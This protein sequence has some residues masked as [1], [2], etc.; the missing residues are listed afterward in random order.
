MNAETARQRLLAQHEQI[1]GCLAECSAL[2]HRL[3]DGEPT[4]IQFDVALS[5]LRSLFD[6][7]NLLETKLIRPLLEGSPDWGGVLVDRMIEEH[8]AEHA[9]FWL[10]LSGSLHEIAAHIDDLVDE[11]DAHM[12]AEERTFLSP[13]VLRTDVIRR[14]KPQPHR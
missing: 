3:H 7:H 6:N 13:L 5:R 10:L 1:R 12:A 2:A 8:L 4:A 9:A 11:L 14:H